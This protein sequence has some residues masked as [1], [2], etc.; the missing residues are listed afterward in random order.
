MVNEEISSEIAAGM[1][2]QTMVNHWMLR[3]VNTESGKNSR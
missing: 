1:I 3:N 2:A